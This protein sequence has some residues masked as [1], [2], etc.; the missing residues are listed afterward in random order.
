MKSYPTKYC[1]FF[2]FF[3]CSTSFA[4]TRLDHHLLGESLRVGDFSTAMSQLNSIADKRKDN[5]PYQLLLAIVNNR[6]GNH[7][8]AL[9]A[10]QV[11][12]GRHSYSHPRLNFEAGWA[13]LIL[14]DYQAAVEHLTAFLN[15]RPN[16]ET[17]AELHEIAKAQLE[18]NKSKE[19]RK[20]SDKFKAWFGLNFG[21]NDNVIGLGQDQARPSDVSNE[22]ALYATLL[23]N[24]SYQ[25]NFG[26]KN[27]LLLNYRL[28]SNFYEELGR[29]NSQLHTLSTSYR[30]VLTNKLGVEAKVDLSDYLLDG[31]SFRHQIGASSRIHYRA[32]PRNRSSAGLQYINSNFNFTPFSASLNRDSDSRSA[33]FSHQIS[34]QNSR[35][36]FDFD[37]GE[38]SSLGSEFDH[39]FYGF[40]I[41][42]THWCNRLENILTKGR[43]VLQISARYR[44]Y[45][46]SNSS[47]FSLSG[48]SR[49]DDQHQY[50]ASL[51]V[52]ISEFFSLYVAYFR[53]RNISNISIYNYSQN[54]TSFGFNHRF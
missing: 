4:E 6:S 22:A 37:F 51:S 52:P 45:D 43:A 30:R 53:T 50:G 21:Y 12:Q 31:D 36:S 15:K 1:L 47:V 34:H 9:E 13:S 7:K 18:S 11:A 48:V 46:Y 8:K 29:Y 17:A 41:K 32:N 44:S 54:Q 24:L 3:Y 39:D 23:G 33:F 5:G 10:I 16:H 14:G 25:E 35:A 49:D 19:P 42:V 38:S 27:A 20:Q 2:L 26:E 28:S 40:G